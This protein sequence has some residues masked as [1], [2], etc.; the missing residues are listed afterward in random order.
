MHEAVE[1][2]TDVQI[3]TNINYHQLV[4]QNGKTLHELWKKSVQSGETDSLQAFLNECLNLTTN[5]I[6]L[7]RTTDCKNVINVCIDLFTSY[8]TG[9]LIEILSDCL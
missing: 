5:M 8:Q 2:K 1:R 4:I 6:E 9:M 3:A 7:I